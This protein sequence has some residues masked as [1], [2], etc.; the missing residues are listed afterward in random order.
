M[1]L[2]V[3]QCGKSVR[4]P[5]YLPDLPLCKDMHLVLYSKLVAAAPVLLTCICFLPCRQ[6][7]LDAVQAHYTLLSP[8]SSNHSS[9]T[10]AG[11]LQSAH[12]DSMAES[13]PFQTPVACPDGMAEEDSAEWETV[14]VKPKREAPT[15]QLN[16][17]EGQAEDGWGEPDL[18]DDSSNGWEVPAKHTK[19]NHQ[20]DS[21]PEGAVAIKAV[22]SNRNIRNMHAADSAADVFSNGQN[23]GARDRSRGRGRGRGRGRY[24]GSRQ[25]NGRNQQQ[26]NEA[27]WEGPSSSAAADSNEMSSSVPSSWG[28]ETVFPVPSPVEPSQL[29]QAIAPRVLTIRRQPQQ[30]QRRQGNSFGKEDNANGNQQTRREHKHHLARGRNAP[31]SGGRHAPSATH[32]GFSEVPVSDATPP[33]Q[34]PMFSF[35]D[36]GPGDVVSSAEMAQGLVEKASSNADLDQMQDGGQR[37]PQRGRG[38]GRGRGRHGRQH[39]Q[40][41]GPA[42][43]HVAEPTS[44]NG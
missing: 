36:F 31:P 16:E 35:G 15:N 30:Q 3:L 23:R 4:C 39:S 28:A 7:R 5:Q 1:R 40:R 27:S 9:A 18:A 22:R 10:N 29:Q 13:S 12:S 43:E 25:H 11:E 44:T 14:P 42:S 37:P 6:R 20:P 26:H 34:Q 8:E 24:N 17:T 19:V 38:R 33:S 2:C 41:R 32:R 21:S